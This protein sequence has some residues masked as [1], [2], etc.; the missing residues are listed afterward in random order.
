[1]TPNHPYPYRLPLILAAM[2]E[3]EQALIEVAASAGPLP[4]P[5]IVDPRLAISYRELLSP[6]TPLLIARSGVGPVNAALTV[7]LITQQRPEIDSLILLGVGGALVSRIGIGELVISS[8]VLQ[9]DSFF[10]L[11][12]GHPRVAA[13]KFVF[14]PE[15]ASA[16]VATYAADPELRSWLASA[17]ANAHAGT[18]LSGNEFVGTVER[19]RA[20]ATLRDDALLVDMEAA[21]IAQV[22][23]RLKLPFVIAKTV[24]DRLQ[25]DGTIESD[26][27]ACLQGASRNAAAVLRHLLH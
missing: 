17:F 23:A 14:T 7:A 22:A 20:I 11:D 6:R 1:M 18:V 19:K 27:W 26:F 21:G 12:F 15:E 5:T 4:E 24:A 9:H 16:H 25:P 10:S 8:S 13:G 3:E 2:P